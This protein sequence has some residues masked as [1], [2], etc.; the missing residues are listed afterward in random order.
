MVLDRFSPATR[1]WFAGAFAEPTPAQLGA[2][3]AMSAGSH[4]LVDRP[5][6]LGQDAGRVPVGD[7]PALASPAA[8]HPAPGTRVLYVSPLKALGRRRRAQPAHPAGRDRRRPPSVLG[9][10]APDITVGV[11][12][13]DTPA[14]ERRALARTPPDILITTPESLFLMLTSPRGRRCAGC[15]P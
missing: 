9:L 4:A 2:W 13:G 15:R 6:R 3:E 8:E 12:S 14:D 10:A 1:D 11:R 5:H 7:R